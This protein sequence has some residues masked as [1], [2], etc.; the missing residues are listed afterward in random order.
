MKTG[1]F[2]ST[3]FFTMILAIDVCDSIHIY[4]MIN[5]NHCR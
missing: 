1:A 5:N 4:G 2:L 3:G